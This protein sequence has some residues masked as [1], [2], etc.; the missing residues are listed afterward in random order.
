MNAVER[1]EKRTEKIK[2][3]IGKVEE[4]QFVEW[5]EDKRRFIVSCLGLQCKEVHISE[6]KSTAVVEVYKGDEKSQS[7][8]GVSKKVS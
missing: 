8:D 1:C 2:I 6:E 4:L 3:E 7:L 5:Y